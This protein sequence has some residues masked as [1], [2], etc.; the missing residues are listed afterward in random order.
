MSFFDKLGKT[1]T[2]TAHSVVEKTKSSTETIR[3]NGLINDEEKNINAAYLNMGRKYAELHTADAEPEFQEFLSAIAASQEKIAEYREQIRKTKHLLICQGCGAEIPETVLYCTKCGA[4]NPV[5]KQ[6]AE[7]RA[8]REAAERAQREAEAAAR[9]AAAQA[10]QAPVVQSAVRTAASPAWLARCSAPSAE[11]PLWLRHLRLHR[12]RLPLRQNS[13]FPS[14]FRL[15][16]LP[17]LPHRLH[18]QLLPQKHRRHSP[19]NRKWL[20]LRKQRLLLRRLHRQ[21]CR[22]GFAPTAAIRFRRRII[23]VPAAVT[24]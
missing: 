1:V 6:L 18:R 17:Y 22:D 24:K 3:L 11:I 2:N 23:S 12:L 15:K 21:K 14:R 20:Q 4:E 16:R 19:Q 10:P 5:G 13:R 7:E 9:Q 8:A